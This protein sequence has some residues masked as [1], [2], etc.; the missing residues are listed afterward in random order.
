VDSAGLVHLFKRA[1]FEVEVNFHW[2]GLAPIFDK[3]FGARVRGHGWAPLL[4]LVAT[5]GKQ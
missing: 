5:G 1:G 3:L 4:S 2:F